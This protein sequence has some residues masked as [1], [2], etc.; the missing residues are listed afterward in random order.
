MA[1]TNEEMITEIRQKLN[2]V[3]KALID[4]DKFKD[5]DQNE[6]KE[7]H[8]FVTSKDS[9]SPSEVTAIADA[10]GELRQ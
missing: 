2:I 6:I 8:Q 4:P 1:T 7:I 10:L 5:A 9:F 3:N